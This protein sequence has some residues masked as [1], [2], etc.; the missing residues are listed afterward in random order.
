MLRYSHAGENARNVAIAALMRGIN[1]GRKTNDQGKQRQVGR[2][3]TI[4]I[5]RLY[6]PKIR[7]SNDTY[8]CFVA[9]SNATE[10]AEPV[11]VDGFTEVINLGRVQ[12][13]CY[14]RRCWWI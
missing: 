4:G 14:T 1:K 5:L 13:S 9:N 11:G 2:L 10:Y 6:V 8:P 3:Y 7:S 12:P